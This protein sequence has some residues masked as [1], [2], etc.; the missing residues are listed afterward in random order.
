MMSKIFMAERK[1]EFTDKLLRKKETA[2]MLGYS[3]RSV[4]RDAAEGKLTKVKVRGCV[5]FRLSEIQAIIN[6]RGV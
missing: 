6:G 1:N 4:D 2:E 3:V 5:C